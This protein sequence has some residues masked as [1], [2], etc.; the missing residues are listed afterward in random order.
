MEEWR[1]IEGYP[2]YEVS[3]I[4][5]VRSLDREVIRKGNKTMLKGQILKPRLRNGYP[6][7]TLY[8][9]NRTEHRSFSVHRLVAEAF[10]DNPDGLPYINHKDEV[11]TNNNKDNLEWCTAKY[12]SNYGTS[13]KRRVEHQDW[14]SIADKQSK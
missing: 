6:S 11:K 8:N 5:N 1:K 3:D 13:I 2:N 12:N 10:I 9:G 7:V 14:N 4:G